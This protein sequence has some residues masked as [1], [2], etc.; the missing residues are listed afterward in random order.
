MNR[1]DL[2]FFFPLSFVLMVCWLGDI[3]P[4]PEE[5]AGLTTQG[6]DRWMEFFFSSFCQSALL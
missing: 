3:W 6:Y 1:L 2:H 5:R 4:Y